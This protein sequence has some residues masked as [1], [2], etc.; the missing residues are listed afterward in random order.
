M[1]D[2]SSLPLDQ[3]ES[4]RDLPLNEQAECLLSV[5]APL[6]QATQYAQCGS[7]NSTLQLY[8]AKEVLRGCVESLCRP[9]SA[10]ETQDLMVLTLVALC[11]RL[12]DCD[13]Q[14]RA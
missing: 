2:S 6:L 4:A 12:V 7:V 14:R 5:I 13:A 3:L 9:L 10:D 11:E 1:N 8:E